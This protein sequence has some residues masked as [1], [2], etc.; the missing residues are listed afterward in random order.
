MIFD[1]P[2]WLL[3]LLPL[4][5]LYWLWKPVTRPMQ[6]LRAVIIILVVL[7]L[8]GIAIRLPSRE[9]V[10]VVIADR[11]KSMPPGSDSREKE[12]IDLV[13]K[14][15]GSKNRLAV[16]SFGAQAVLEHAPQHGA[17][18]GFNTKIPGDASELAQAIDLALSCIPSG[19]PGRIL[20]ISDGRFTGPDPV[21]ISSRAALR[22]IALDYRLLER[23]AAQ[24]TAVYRL[25]APQQVSAG[26]A[27]MINAWITSPFQQDITYE[28][29]RGDTVIASAM[30]KFDAGL[31]RLVFRDKAPSP[32]TAAY[33]LRIS[34]S[35]PDAV[36][37]NNTARMLVGIQGGA[38]KIL[39]VSSG[40]DS[41]LARILAANKIDV[42]SRTAR[43]VS[44]SLENLTNYSAV[45]L[46]DVTA[47][48]IGSAGMETIAEWLTHTNAGLMFAGGKH[49][50]GPGGYFKSP[51][52][53][54]MPVS[55]ELRQEHRKFS[56]AIVVALDC[57]GSMAASV[58]GGK[59]KIG[60]ADL[61][62]VQV[63]DMLSPADE[64]GC[65][66]IN[67]SPHIIAMLDSASVNMGA[68]SAILRIDAGSNG[69][70]IDKALDT[71]MKM[72]G[73]AKSQNRHI[74]LF[75]DAADSRQELG[76]YHQLLDDCKRAD[77]TVSAIGLGHDTDCDADIL[78]EIAQLGKGEIFFTDDPM[79]LPRLFAQDTFIIARSAF[80]EDPTKVKSAPG[81]L[82]LAGRSFDITAA[83][84]GYNLCYFRPGANLSVITAD[85]Y[86]APVVASWQAG[87]GRVLC[88]TGQ[89][90]GQYT[91][92]IGA[93]P[94][95]GTFIS[96]LVRWTA[97]QSENSTDT[98]AVTQRLE[99]GLAT[100]QIQLDPD[101]KMEPFSTLPTVTTLRGTIGQ[102]PTVEKKSIL[103]K[104]ADTLAIDIP[105]TGTETILSTISAAGKN[106]TLSPQCLPY[107]PE[108]APVAAGGEDTLKKLARMTNGRERVNLGGIWADMPRRPRLFAMSPYFLVLAVILLLLEVL[109]RRTSLISTHRLRIAR[110][111]L[112]RPE[113]ESRPIAVSKIKSGAKEPKSMPGSIQNQKSKI[114]NEQTP[115]TASL[116][117]ARKKAD[118]Y[119]K[120]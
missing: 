96:T 64:F 25:D 26:E 36:P 102:K 23:P 72:L 51:L 54:V 1:Q 29:K 59:T 38:K 91:G 93:W 101:R 5:A 95:Y 98:F 105:I 18:A 8:A 39:C 40:P 104:D 71:A 17:F 68:K 66:A 97:G 27:F 33:T 80:I 120:K 60:L 34:P 73:S 35:A 113:P 103:Y 100:L 58:G 21:T 56:T 12:M 110:I 83:L 79:E 111:R 41:G 2:I 63:L 19:A 115:L 65:V 37:E 84:G 90:S 9:G 15:A 32:G 44:W 14:D 49:A 48:D 4:G 62:T 118:Q 74:V 77:I 67:D 7:S 94:D 99:N 31:T 45:I 50:Y 11:S 53:P 92:P 108:F 109:E 87:T 57:S 24:D 20:L 42:E 6:I 28:L 69:I 75:A 46:E 85:E 117:T 112:D 107:S 43:Q 47:N 106:Y 22:G 89:V 10:L 76:N 81:L 3:L 78:R 61:S 13:Q 119:L 88:Y 70:Y 52:E 55:M 82:T 16:V 86:A 116:Q 114:Q 30:R